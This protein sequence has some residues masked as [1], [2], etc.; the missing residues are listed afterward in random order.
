MK[1]ELDRFGTRSDETEGRDRDAVA[2][3]RPPGWQELDEKLKSA[4]GRNSVFQRASV[5]E[6]QRVPVPG[7]RS[8]V[9]LSEAY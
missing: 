6:C 5:S 4:S 9:S 1:R 3:V 2:G 7:A 8:H